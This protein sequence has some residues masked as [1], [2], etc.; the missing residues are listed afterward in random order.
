MA[1]TS[2]HQSP[3]RSTST[4]STRNLQTPLTSNVLPN[5]NRE[6]AAAAVDSRDASS[7]HSN[8]TDLGPEQ[9]DE[10]SSSASSNE[11]GVE[12]GAEDSREEES[13]PEHIETSVQE[14][15]DVSP[16]AFT[17][18]ASYHTAQ[19][20]TTNNNPSIVSESTLYQPTRTRLS[21]R[22]SKG[23]NRFREHIDL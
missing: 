4:V 14:A 7:H 16:G 9:Q 20:Q 15:V 19:S 22:S 11:S 13:V 5:E 8:R 18:G 23:R 6:Y 3:L 12:D 1:V 21:A 10:W 2:A 17:A